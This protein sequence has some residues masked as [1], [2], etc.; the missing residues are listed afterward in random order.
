MEADFLQ[1]SYGMEIYEANLTDIMR[2][3][4]LSGILYNATR[5]R[6]MIGVGPFAKLLLRVAGF[7]DIVRVSGE[8]YWKSWINVIA[9][10]GWTKRW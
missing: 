5:V 3:S 8:N 1:V 6:E 2:Q 7:P 4:E 10:L 9:L